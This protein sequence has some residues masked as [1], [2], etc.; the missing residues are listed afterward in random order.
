MA[1]PVCSRLFC[2]SLSLSLSLSLN[3]DATLA[4]GYRTTAQLKYIS[5]CTTKTRTAKQ[6]TWHGRKQTNPF[7]TSSLNP[8]ALSLS[9]AMWHIPMCFY[10][11]LGVWSGLPISLLH[12]PL[13]Q[14]D[15]G[16]V[17]AKTWTKDNGHTMNQPA[18]TAYFAV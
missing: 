15:V 2:N 7:G 13:D 6:K 8:L 9:P 18:F 10:R 16:F 3:P 5:M 11:L 17:L 4:H 1:F 12:Q 14:L